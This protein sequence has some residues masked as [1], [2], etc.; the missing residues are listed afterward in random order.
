MKPSF[1][2]NSA[3]TRR[4][5]LKSSA[6]GILG[7]TA[8]NHPFRFSI[9]GA[10]QA[11]GQDVQLG[12]VLK[13]S[14]PI[15]ASPHF[16]STVLRTETFN[17]VLEIDQT[18]EG[19]SDNAGNLVWY[20]LN[21]DGCIHSSGIQVV[22]N[23]I[24]PVL[25][26]LNPYGVLAQVTVPFTQAWKARQNAYQ[27]NQLYFYGSTHW[28]TGLA[29]DEQGNF[30]YKVKDDR[31]GYIYYVS[32]SHLYIVD[33]E[34]LLPVNATDPPREKRIEVNQQDQS[35]TAYEGDQP[36]FFSPMS[37]GIKNDERDYSTPPGEYRIHYKRPSRHMV[38]GGVSGDQSPDLH[39]VPWVSYFT[40]SGIAFHGTYWHNDFGLPRSFGC[41]NLPIPAARWIY[42]WT[43]PVVPPRAKTF[44]S[45]QGTRVIVN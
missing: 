9:K 44:V 23:I 18:M 43:L 29:K 8:L 30:F 40:N 25:S 22:Q 24:N 35:I 21:D 39:G 7:M 16:S 3:I 15:H 6:L 14:I 2:L 42:L 28:V 32:A 12:R 36:V 26:N 13:S 27:K 20:R 10:K 34:E 5:F 4:G 45:N 37:S 38:H 1:D 19:D 11:K 33:E 31:W 41:V 17:A